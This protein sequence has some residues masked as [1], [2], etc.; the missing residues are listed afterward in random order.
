MK[1][2]IFKILLKQIIYVTQ[3]SDFSSVRSSPVLA[4]GTYD[5]H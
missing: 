4:R 2:N 3:N 5:N 1:Q